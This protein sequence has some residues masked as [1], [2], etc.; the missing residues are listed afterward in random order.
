[1]ANVLGE[2]FGKIANSIRGGLG[3]IGKMSPSA[4]PGKVDEIVALMNTPFD[5]LNLALNGING[6]IVGEEKYNVTFNYGKGSYTVS[7]YEG[8]DCP[9]PVATGKIAVPTK[10]S[11]RYANYT[12]AG[13]SLTNGGEVDEKALLAIE[14]HRTVYAA[15]KEE[16]IY[17]K[18]G[19]CGEDATYKVNPDYVVT[20]SGTG[21]IANYES[22]VVESGQAPWFS[23]RDKITSVVICEGIT[24]I[25]LY[26]FQGCSALESVSLPNGL[27]TISMGAFD[28]CSALESVDLPE[29]IMYIYSYAFWGCSLSNITIPYAMRYFECSAFQCDTLTSVVFERTDGWLYGTNLSHLNDNIGTEMTEEEA[30]NPSFAVSFIMNAPVTLFVNNKW[31]EELV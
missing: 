16:Y 20:V 11:T 13:W 10:E 25:G 24:Q 7:V 23:Y 12:F 30:A 31:K 26:A 17:I 9:D 3:D 21:A 4:F 29:T 28:D 2:L 6:E 14:G 5:E 22:D 1:M 27:T 8:Y 19:K 15:F 18:S